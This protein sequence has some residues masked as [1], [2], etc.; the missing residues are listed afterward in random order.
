[1][2]SDEE[3][4]RILAPVASSDDA[5]TVTTFTRPPGG[6]DW[7]IFAAYGPM[8]FAKAREFLAALGV[9]VPA[10]PPD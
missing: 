9:E 6:T 4:M 2:P 8:T 5:W 10:T 7:Q 3:V 1:M